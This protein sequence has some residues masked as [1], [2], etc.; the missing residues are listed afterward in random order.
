MVSI[1]SDSAAMNAIIKARY[2]AVA[3]LRRKQVVE[4]SIMSCE[5]ISGRRLQMAIVHHL[6][7]SFIFSGYFPSSSLGTSVLD[8]SRYCAWLTAGRAQNR[9]NWYSR[10]NY[11]WNC[12]NMTGGIA[13]THDGK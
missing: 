5:R 6:F 1:K 3:K 13:N 7:F 12:E 8:L 9:I 10:S 11:F 2:A 4:R